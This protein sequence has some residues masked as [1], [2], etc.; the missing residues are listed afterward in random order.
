M[1][2]KVKDSLSSYAVDEKMIDDFKGKKILVIGDVMVDKYIIGEVSRISPEAP[3][4][5]LHMKQEKRVLGGA[6]NAVKNLLNLGAEVTLLSVVGDDLDGKWILG[7][8][9]K[10]AVDTSLIVI[11][12]EK[13]TIQKVR[14]IN[15]MYHQLMRLDIED[16]REVEDSL[17]GPIIDK[18]KQKISAFDGL[19]ISDY[20]KGVVG[21]WVS[22]IIAIFRRG[23]KPVVVDGKPINKAF[24]KGC[25]LITPN[26]KEASEMSGIQ[27]KDSQSLLNVGNDLMNKLQCSVLITKGKEGMSLFTGS[28]I[29]HIKALAKSKDEVTDICGAGDT[30]AAV[31][32]LALS[33]GLSLAEGAKLAN[34]AAYLVVKKKGVVAVDS[35][36]LKRE[37]LR[38]I[39]DLLAEGIEVN[40][41]L[42]ERELGNIKRFSELLVEAYRAGN[43][44]LV[45]GN[46][47]SASD[48]QHLVGELVGRFKLERK[49]LPAIALNSETATLTA[50]AN[51]YGYENVFERQVEALVQE[52]DIV[53]GI[54]TSGNSANVVKA[55]KK[56]KEMGAKIVGLTGGTGGEIKNIADLSIVVP[57]ANTPRIQE[58]HGIVIHIVCE[59]L[60]KELAN[61]K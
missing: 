41:R 2:G 43:K 60:E 37:C 50:V 45:F 30:V 22:E 52:S 46:G 13:P 9:N 8:M 42:I 59:L 7:E 51:D 12:P 61:E 20:A 39:S 32:T 10:L 19:L 23:N 3:V 31:M 16:T 11:H 35:Y 38:G 4:Q 53:V 54:T 25:S 57:S 27:I 55:L 28:S 40:Q 15:G 1:A 34:L 36:E 49:G 14:F 17:I 5:V 48:A 24:F 33:S 26:K 21:E 29:E 47:G 58:A 6:G 56:A 18:L 44:V